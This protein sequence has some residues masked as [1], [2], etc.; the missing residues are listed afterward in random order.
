VITVKKTS[1]FKTVCKDNSGYM[2]QVKQQKSKKWYY[3]AAHRHI[4]NALDKLNVL[5]I[6]TSGLV[7]PVT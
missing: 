7:D 3:L 2:T 1:Q 5:H 6:S 4:V